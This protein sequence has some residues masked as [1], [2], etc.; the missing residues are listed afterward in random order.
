MRL[1]IQKKGEPGGNKEQGKVSD[2]FLN[3][4]HRTWH[5]R[6]VCGKWTGNCRTVSG[7][8]YRTGINPT[9]WNEHHQP[10][11]ESMQG[12]QTLEAWCKMQVAYSWQTPISIVLAWTIQR[13]NHCQKVPSHGN[14]SFDS[15][16]FLLQTSP[17]LRLITIY[18]PPPSKKNGLAFKN[19]ID[20]ISPFLEALS[21]ASGRLLISGDFN[22][23]ADDPLDK[24]CIEFLNLLYALGIEQHVVG[25]THRTGHTLDL[26][27]TRA[28]DKILPTNTVQDDILSDHYPIHCDLPLRQMRA[29]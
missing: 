9:L 27:L 7:N 28:R 1:A 17:L 22:I 15:L 25:S 24:D 5:Y 26:V 19:F 18:I 21:I 2:S 13:F 12:K 10:S 29:K 11:L 23:H 3:C 6:Q 20:E 14:A 16:E 8:R 4:C